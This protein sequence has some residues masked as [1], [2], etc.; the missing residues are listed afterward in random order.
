MRATG[1]AVRVAINSCISV[2]TSYIY[3]NRD[4][5]SHVKANA[6]LIDAI[7]GSFD[8]GR[9][10]LG[11]GCGWQFDFHLCSSSVAEYPVTLPSGVWEPNVA[12][13]SFLLPPAS[14]ITAAELESA[15]QL[16]LGV[17]EC[18]HLAGY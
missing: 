2:L 7:R 10:Y 5:V 3:D 18:L 13:S 8:G 15:R 6:I 1:R 16:L 9:S 17:E 14:T 11:V 4:I 12:S